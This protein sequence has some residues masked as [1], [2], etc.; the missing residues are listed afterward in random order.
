LF[1]PSRLKASNNTN[2]Q[3]CPAVSSKYNEE[4]ANPVSNTKLT[5]TPTLAILNEFPMFQ[6]FSEHMGLKLTVEIQ[7]FTLQ[8][9]FFCLTSISLKKEICNFKPP[10]YSILLMVVLYPSLY[11]WQ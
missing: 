10:T 11:K 4:L 1:K 6:I 9:K 2:P 7:I 5:P 3:E 8:N